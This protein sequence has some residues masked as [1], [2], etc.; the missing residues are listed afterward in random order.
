[1]ADQTEPTVKKLDLTI[2]RLRLLLA[3]VSAR[4]SA[5]TNQRRTF[6]DQRSKLITFALYG[7]TTLDSVLG[8][9]AD[10]E[11]R[12]SGVEATLR[13]LGAVRVRAE[14]ELESLQLTKGIEEAKV[15]LSELQAKQSEPLAGAEPLAPEAIAAEIGRLQS[16][17]AEASER[18]AK[19]VGQSSRRVS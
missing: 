5:L 10:T 14:S 1:M 2:A 11:E 3:D 9:L 8:M 19:H 16:L 12:L 17:I 18:A 7:D 6:E 13:S 15:L 4:E